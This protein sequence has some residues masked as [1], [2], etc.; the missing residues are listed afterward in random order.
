M[1]ARYLSRQRSI[2]ALLLALAVGAAPATAATPA[3]PVT[4]SFSP[5]PTI[6]PSTAAMVNGVTIERDA[7]QQLVKGLARAEASPPD[8]ARIG[9]LTT[10]ALESLIDLELLYQEA[11]RRKIQLADSEVERQ[12]AEVRRHFESEEKFAAALASR[13]MTPADLRLDTR[14]TLMAERL[15]QATVWRDLRVS[16]EEVTTFYEENRA[17]LGKPLDEIDGSIARMLLDDKK[18]ARRAELVAELRK[19]AAIVRLPPYGSG[20]AGR[21]KVTPGAKDSKRVEPTPGR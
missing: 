3:T 8:S 2:S 7:V 9:E 18:A 10:A 21:R 16:T 1:R 14:R 11:V 13:G 15:L 17:E 5:A 12:V 20:D 19:R 6:P 4:P